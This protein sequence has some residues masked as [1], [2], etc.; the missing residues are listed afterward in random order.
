MNPEIYEIHNDKKL[1]SSSPTGLLP[2]FI[3]LAI[4]LGTFAY[5]E[6]AYAT[7]SPNSSTDWNDFQVTTEIDTSGPF[8]LAEDN[9][10]DCQ[11]ELGLQGYLE[12]TANV[13]STNGSTYYFGNIEG[14]SLA[15]PG[16]SSN[17]YCVWYYNTTVSWH[18]DSTLFCYDSTCSTPTP[19]PTPTPS[20]SP[21]PVDL[22]ELVLSSSYSS[23]T[24][25][26]FFSIFFILFTTALWSLIDSMKGGGNT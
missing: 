20:D 12:V 8:V 26:I 4:C 16:Y 9:G 17:L 14:Q 1:R 13:T 23:F 19:T 6:I 2:I 11:P 21:S 15:D 5:Y 7:V 22:Q 3:A 10:T 24:Y 18:M 25:A